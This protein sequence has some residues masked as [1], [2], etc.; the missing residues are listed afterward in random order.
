[1]SY[2]TDT[3]RQRHDHARHPSSDTAVAGD[4]PAKQPFRAYP[5]GRFHIDIAG[6]CTEEVK[7]YLFVAVDRTS[8][9]AFARPM[10]KATVATARVG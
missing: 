5:I 4:K 1:M 3:S 9:Y 2:V 7:L 10:Q 6:V 8:K